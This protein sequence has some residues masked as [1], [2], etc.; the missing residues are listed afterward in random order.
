MFFI[1]VI[2]MKNIRRSPELM[3]LMF[4]YN[5]VIWWN[6]LNIGTGIKVLLTAAL[7]LFFLF[8]LVR[9]EKIQADDKRL[10]RMNRGSSLI[11]LGGAA[12]LLELIV[13]VVWFGKTSAGVA[14]KTG[15]VVMPVLGIG[16]TVLAGALRVAV[17]SKQIKLK[18]HI[19]MLLWWWVPVVNIFLIRR[20][21][22][23]A[24]REFIVESDKLEL[25]NARAENEICRTKYPVLMVHGIFFRDWQL[26]NYW[27]RVPAS[28]IRN[29][30]K[31]YYGNQQS[32]MAIKDSAAE[33]R[34]AIL[35]VIEETGAE[36]VNII[37]HSKGGLDSRYAISCLGMDKY[38]ATLTTVNTPHHGCDMVDFLLDRLPDS[39]AQFIARKYN[40][41]FTKLGDT[42]PDFMAGVHDLSAVRAKEYDNEMPDSPDVSYRSCMSVMSR[43][44]SA[45]FPLNISYLLIKKLNGANDGLVWEKSAEHGR[46]RLVTAPHKRGISHGD[47]IDLMREN[48]EGYDVR[49]FYV[50]VVRELKNEGY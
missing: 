8:S 49:E 43:A 18:D 29:G 35:S 14:A 22:K 32:A 16:V 9:S 39:V 6:E 30:A 37:A 36:K 45:G 27:G 48:I 21:Y 13:L 11:W 46:F 7:S 4:F 25:E 12:A 44:G 42:S 24:R 26:L 34:A 15:A 20:F 31:V 17:S 47:V 19:M 3:L 5:T 41:I 10:K 23:T 1:G 33:L 40:K 38:V 50:D 28:L 2:M